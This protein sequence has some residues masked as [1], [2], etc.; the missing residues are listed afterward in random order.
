M[1]SEKSIYTESFIAGED[2][3]SSQYHGVKMNGN[4][5]VD[6]IDAVTDKPVGVLVGDP[7]D[8]QE[9][10]VMIVGRTPLVLGD[11]MTAGEYF[12]FDANGHAIP[13]DAGTDTTMYA[14]GQII[15]G[16]ASGEKGEGVVGVTPARGAQ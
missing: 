13:W 10:L 14:Y 5:T 2:L 6:V 15:S 8:G 11:T 9:A 7:E 3:S 16:G 4:R 12:R 1:A